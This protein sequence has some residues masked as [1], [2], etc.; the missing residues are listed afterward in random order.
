MQPSNKMSN[1]QSSILFNNLILDPKDLPKRPDNPSSPSNSFYST[2]DSIEFKDAMVLGML[3]QIPHKDPT[4]IP[5]EQCKAILA[6]IWA[7]KNMIMFPDHMVSA[8][9]ERGEPPSNPSS[10]PSFFGHG[11]HFKQD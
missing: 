8:M 9:N 10:D 5:A 6:K 2:I 1:Q 3:G 7:L 4:E 11:D